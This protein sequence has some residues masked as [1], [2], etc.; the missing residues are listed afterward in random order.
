MLAEVRRRAAPML[1]S[2]T[3]RRVYLPL[4]LYAAAPLCRMQAE[5]RRR[6]PPIERIE[7]RYTRLLHRAPPHPLYPPM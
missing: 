6:P 2:S 1:E 7:R 3:R 4:Y 5:V